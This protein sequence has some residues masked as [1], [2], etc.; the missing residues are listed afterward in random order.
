MLFNKSNH[1]GDGSIGLRGDRFG[2]GLCGDIDICQKLIDQLQEHP[3][4]MFSLELFN[5]ITKFLAQ[6][7][8][9]PV[10]GYIQYMKVCRELSNDILGQKLLR[11]LQG[12]TLIVDGTVGGKRMNHTGSGN[13]QATGIDIKNIAVNGVG[14]FAAD[15]QQK[16]PAS[17]GMGRE[18]CTKIK[19]IFIDIME[20]F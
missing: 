5:V 2:G 15:Y 1:L 14:Q 16:F 11:Y 20:T 10:I 3:V 4:P 7:G 13:D 18:I 9:V 8:N 17:M 12:V 19:Q 6:G